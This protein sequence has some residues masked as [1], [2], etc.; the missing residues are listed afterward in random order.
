MKKE[1]TYKNKDTDKKTN[2]VNSISEPQEAY[3]TTF[4]ISENKTYSHEEVFGNL[5]KRLKE[6]Y[7]EKWK[8]IPLFIRKKQTMI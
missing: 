6:F 8:N 3:E 7:G 2:R 4:S 1:S 5:R